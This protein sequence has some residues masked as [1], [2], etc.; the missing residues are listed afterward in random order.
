M[1]EGR[2]ARQ[3]WETGRQLKPARWNRIHGP[4]GRDGGREWERR[5]EEREGEREGSF[6]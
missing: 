5:E 3:A 6:V 4:G 2:P 1:S